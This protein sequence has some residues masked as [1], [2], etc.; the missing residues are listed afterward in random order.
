LKKYYYFLPPL[1]LCLIFVFFQLPRLNRSEKKPEYPFK[2]LHS[3]FSDQW[4]AKSRALYLRRLGYSKIEIVREAL[5][6][7]Q[8]QLVETDILD[9]AD[10]KGKLISKRT[11]IKH[12]N[13][14]FVLVDL[15]GQL[16]KVNVGQMSMESLKSL[17]LKGELLNAYENFSLVL[18]K[19]FKEDFDQYSYQ[20][21][22]YNIK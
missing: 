16:T 15:D 19:E 21:Q 7:R 17:Q 5:K 20:Y 18:D 3:S 8:S 4:M 2:D 10:M 11:Q 12:W 13:P 22:D 14:S 9:F 1:V 6:I